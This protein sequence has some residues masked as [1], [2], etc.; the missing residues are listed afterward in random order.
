MSL[1]S[2]VAA[3]VDSTNALTNTVNGLI[4]G[5]QAQV[6]AKKAQ[7][8][9]MMASWGYDT[10]TINVGALRSVTTVSAAVEMIRRKVIRGTVTIQLDDGNYI[11]DAVDVSGIPYA[12]GVLIRGNEPNP[13]ACKITFTP[14]GVAN[15][16]GLFNRGSIGLVVAGVTFDGSSWDRVDQAVYAANGGVVW[17]KQGTVVIRNATSALSAGVGGVIIAPVISV[18]ACMRGAVAAD[19][20]LIDCG[21]GASFTGRGRTTSNVDGLGNVFPSC[22]LFASNGGQILCP[23]A[24]ITSYTKGI[25]AAVAGR[26]RADGAQVSDADQAVIAEFGSIINCNAYVTNAATAAVSYPSTATNCRTGYWSAGGSTVMAGGARVAA[27]GGVVERGYV[28]SDGARLYATGAGCAGATQYGYYAEG[29][30]LLAAWSTQ[31]N[32]A[33][34]ATDY[35][36]THGTVGNFGALIYRS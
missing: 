36:L 14:S 10:T 19:G 24:T 20:G 3:L 5:L 27:G 31:A 6:D 17:L 11:E 4:S 34:N 26:I 22:G 2:Q 30:A 16:R 7:L 23:R 13:A 9:A 21:L 28:S 12:A 25:W 32:N 35:N 18:S 33:G 8:D 29:L 1:E 15:A